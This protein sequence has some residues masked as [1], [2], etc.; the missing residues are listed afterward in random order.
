[1]NQEPVDA[2]KGHYH[3][4]V[5]SYMFEW[6]CE[7]MCL[8]QTKLPEGDVKTQALELMGSH[9][10]SDIQLHHSL[11]KHCLNTST[12]ELPKVPLR[13]LKCHGDT[14]HISH[15]SNL[16]D[17]LGREITSGKIPKKTKIRYKS[18]PL[19]K[20]ATEL[21]T[22][23]GGKVIV[24]LPKKTAR[25]KVIPTCQITSSDEEDDDGGGVTGT[26]TGTDTG[27]VTGTDTGTDTWSINT[28]ALQEIIVDTLGN[29]ITEV[30]SIPDEIESLTR[31]LETGCVFREIDG[32][33]GEY[34][35][36]YCLEG[37][38]VIWS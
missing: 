6:C 7:L 8:L 20:L 23:S 16:A 28:S 31:D 26:V 11:D 30:A 1:M 25:K 9:I 29:V 15:G 35:G 32:Q 13:Y 10:P 33:P 14:S 17:Q 2:I 37:Q 18:T 19:F 4:M 38:R 21:D 22:G 36:K 27:T 24:P 12:L 3:N 5:K 34:V